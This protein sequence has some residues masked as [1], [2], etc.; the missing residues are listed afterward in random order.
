MQVPFIN[1][2]KQYNSIKADVDTAIT[3]AI[4]EF[5]FCQGKSVREFEA[6][7]ANRIGVNECITTGSGT[8]ALF[9]ILKCLGVQQGDEVITPALSWISTAETISLCGAS[10]VFADADP[11]H[12]TI[13]PDAVK[14]KIT[15]RTKAVIAVHLYGQSSELKSLVSICE[16]YNIF[17][18]EDCAQAHLTSFQGKVV[19]RFGI[20]NAFS[21]YPTK[22]LGAF[23]DAGCIATNDLKLAEKLRR[24]CN[25][26]ALQRNDHLMEGM[27][28]RMDTLQAAILNAKMRFLESWNAQRQ[29]HAKQY[30]ALL[31]DVPQV[32]LPA[33]R[34]DSFHSFHI[35]AINCENRDLLKEYLAGKGIQT[36]IH[37]PKALPDLP[38]YLEKAYSPCPVASSVTRSILSLPIYPELDMREIEYVAANIRAFYRI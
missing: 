14:A 15:P 1:L 2:E 26:G 34:P 6:L 21:F 25:H 29:S 38:F 7:F 18:I 13:D 37:Y 10:P 24:F 30:M 36:I 23:G 12:Y 22:N 27:N 35:F 3:D 11:I 28:S 31:K 19:G 32:V 4:H 8:D 5:Q 20:A 17:L 16:Q 33:Q 9:A